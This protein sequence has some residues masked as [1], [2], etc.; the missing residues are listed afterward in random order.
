MSRDQE[1]EGPGSGQSPSLG[2]QSLESDTPDVITGVKGRGKQLRG[3]SCQQHHCP[4]EELCSCL[5]A[6]CPCLHTWALKTLGLRTHMNLIKMKNSS[7]QEKVHEPTN[8]LRVERLR[9]AYF[10]VLEA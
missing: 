6:S 8:G 4:L 3:P 9:I 7:H 5:A 2:Q 1:E 10:C